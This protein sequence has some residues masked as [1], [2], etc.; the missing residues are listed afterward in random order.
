MRPFEIVGRAPGVEG[1]LHL[2]KIA[3]ALEREDLVLQ[4]AVEAL[5][6]AAALRVIGPAVQDRDAELEQPDTKLGPALSG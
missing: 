6:F 1:A 5:V 2:G 3:E 4:G